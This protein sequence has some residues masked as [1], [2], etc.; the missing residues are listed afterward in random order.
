MR[1]AEPMRSASFSPLRAL[2]ARPDTEH[3][4]AIRALAVG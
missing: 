3:E 2:A 4:Q 1:P